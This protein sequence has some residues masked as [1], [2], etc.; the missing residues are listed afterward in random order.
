[1]GRKSDVKLTSKYVKELSI[2]NDSDRAVVFD[3]AVRGFG[4]SKYK[5]GKVSFFIETKGTDGNVTRKNIKTF[6]HFSE[7]TS[8]SEIRNNAERLILTI[9]AVLS[10][11]SEEG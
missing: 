10:S 6:I 7:L 3:S 5:T 4:V 2:P 8:V 1:M 9:K 11:S